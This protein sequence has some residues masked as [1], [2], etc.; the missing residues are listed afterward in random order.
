MGAIELQEVLEIYSLKNGN[1]NDQTLWSVERL[2]QLGE[3][4]RLKHLVTIPASFLALSG[5]LLYDPASKLIYGAGGRLQ[6]GQ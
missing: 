4:V 6:L 5:R 3:R 1:W 2:P